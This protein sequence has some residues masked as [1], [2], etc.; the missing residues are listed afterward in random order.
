MFLLRLWLPARETVITDDF[1]EENPGNPWVLALC[2]GLVGCEL[3]SESAQA[4]FSV[5]CMNAPVVHTV[6]SL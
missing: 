5:I 6:L 1:P 2:R 4:C 3:L